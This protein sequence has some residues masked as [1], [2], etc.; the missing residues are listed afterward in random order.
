MAFIDDMRA[1]GHAVESTCRVLS[2]QGCPVAARTY[3]SW[4]QANRPIATRTMTDAVITDALIATKGTPEALYGR[5][6]MTHWLRRQGHEVAFC[7]VDRLMRDLG[8]NGVRRGRGVRT[9]VP[10]KDGHRAGDLLDRDFTASAPNVRWVADFTYCRT[11]SGFVYVAFV[12]DV[13]AQRIVGWHAATDRRTDLVLTPLR[14]ALWDRNRHG[15]PVEPGQ[16][17]H[18][19]DAGSQYTSIRF[20]EH[21]AL[22]EIAPSIGTV[23]DAYDNALMETVIGLFKTECI[24]TTVFHDGPYRTLADVEY[25]TAGWVDWY[26][27]R[28]LHSSLGMSTPVEFE[29]A[30]Y[31]ARQPAGSTTSRAATNP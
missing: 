4:K 13:F 2:S 27:H 16:L 31:A 7:T 29:Q 8:M 25:A 23:G 9:T 10:A 1:A 6:K 19:S 15:T 3:R 22:E 20:T 12:L 30:H 14:I 11:W 24:T 18:H 17:L 21:L 26:N 5:R 28:R